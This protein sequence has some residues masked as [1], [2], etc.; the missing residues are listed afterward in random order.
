MVAI[1]KLNDEYSEEKQSLQHNLV[2]TKNELIQIEIE[3]KNEIESL[4]NTISELQMH[5]DLLKNQLA[6]ATLETHN[7]KNDIDDLTEVVSVHNSVAAIANNNSLKTRDVATSTQQENRQ[8]TSSFI[9][10]CLMF[11]LFLILF[12]TMWIYA[13]GAI[14]PSWAYIQVHHDHL[15]PQ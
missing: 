15:P 11:F 14:V 6:N 1:K 7:L 12:F 8:Q 10:S 4:N 13:F 9:P 3:K 2:K 5:Q